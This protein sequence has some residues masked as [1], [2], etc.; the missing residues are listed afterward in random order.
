MTEYSGFRWS[1]FFLAEYANIFIVAS[2]AVTLFLG[3]WLSPFPGAPWLDYAVPIGLLLLLAA[4]CLYLAAPRGAQNL[5]RGVLVRV[6]GRSP[7]AGQLPA[8]ETGGGPADYGRTRVCV[9]G[10]G[11]AVCL[12]G[13]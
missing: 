3:G 7:E 4:L 5:I 1:L 9:P 10:R 8:P 12:A 13:V 6:A 11:C 2:I